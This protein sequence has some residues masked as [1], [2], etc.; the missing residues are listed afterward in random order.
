MST[1]FKSCNIVLF[2]SAAVEQQ[3]IEW[4]KNVSKCFKTR[5][6]LDDQTYHPHITLYQ[7]HY[8]TNSIEK[9]QAVLAEI[10]K[11]VP[12]FEITMHNLSA[13]SGF[14][15]YDATKSTEIL[16]LHHTVIEALNPLREGILTAADRQI[17]ADPRVPEKFKQ[18]IQHYA[19]AFAKESYTA[20]E[21]H[22]PGGL[23]GSRGSTKAFTGQSYD[24]YRPRIALDQ[25]RR[26]W[27]V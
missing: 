24:L 18:N 22:A 17:L 16:D 25:C 9:V 11:K 4:S 19:Y 13:L 1:E 15:F 27:H 20:S 12:Q 10:T 7:A 23:S 3:A 5:Y 2:P 8:P 6:V 26:R 21:H 14:I